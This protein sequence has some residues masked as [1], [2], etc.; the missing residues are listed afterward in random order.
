MEKKMMNKKILFLIVLIIIVTLSVV[1]ATENHTKDT[2]NNIQ[3]T[4]KDSTSMI[5]TE[6]KNTNKTKVNIK[7]NNVKGVIGE[8][9]T[10]K[11]SITDENGKKVNGGNL[12]FKLN[13]KSLRT[14]KKF[15]TNAQALKI[16]VKNGTASVTITADAYLRNTKNLTASYSGTGNYEETQSDVTTAQIQKR[17]ASIMVRLMK[18]FHTVKN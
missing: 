14:D 16:P 11:A 9:I 17:R 4:S 7:I 18:Q 3:K 15:N 8:N 5:K 2:H 6:T 13:G 1:S 12:V 10:L